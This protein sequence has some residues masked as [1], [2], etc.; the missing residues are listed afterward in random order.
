MW[1]QDLGFRA[2]AEFQQ[3][4]LRGVLSFVGFVLGWGLCEMG[5]NGRHPDS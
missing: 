4:S 1:G 3:V 5:I 2:L